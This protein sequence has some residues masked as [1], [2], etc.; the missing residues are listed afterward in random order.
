MTDPAA[1]YAAITLFCPKCGHKN[2]EVVAHLRQRFKYACRGT[3]RP[4]VF[5]FDD[6]KY[7]PL[8]QKLAKAFDEFDATS[9]EGE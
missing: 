4:Y 7:G 2:S 8:L 9:D 1:E 5:T 3:G 6:N